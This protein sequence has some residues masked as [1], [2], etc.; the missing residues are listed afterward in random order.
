MKFSRHKGPNPKERTVLK[1][2]Y[3]SKHRE[4]VI[5]HIH[6]CR[7]THEFI[8]TQ[9]HMLTI[10]T[11]MY[12]HTLE[13]T[14]TYAHEHTCA[15]T[16]TRVCTHSHMHGHTCAYTFITYIHVCTHG[17]TNMN[18]LTCAFMHVIGTHI[19]THM[20]ITYPSFLPGISVSFIFPTQLR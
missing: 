20:Y 18:I 11:H 16:F 7:Q 1:P 14:C 19:H 15:H 8:Y 6:R 3:I 12:M 13:H 9:A 4:P 2:S 5:C 17:H 10:H